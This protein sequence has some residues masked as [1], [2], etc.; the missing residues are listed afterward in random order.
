MIN[1]SEVYISSDQPT[2]CPQCS[3]RTKVLMDFSHTKDQTEIHQ[4]IDQNCRY[5]FVMQYDVDFDN[6]NLL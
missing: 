2:T 4:C 3:A 5:E 6:G 1:F